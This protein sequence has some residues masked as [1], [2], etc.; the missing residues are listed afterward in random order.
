MARPG[1]SP[2]A[3]LFHVY[4]SDKAALKA[5]SALIAPL[6]ELEQ[7]DAGGAPLRKWRDPAFQTA[8][9]RAAFLYGD[10]TL[11]RH[12]ELPPHLV[13]KPPHEQKRWFERGR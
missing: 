8:R 3:H 6:L 2:F 12:G 5:E 13:D 4:K 9:D 1:P 7:R 11:L 10:G